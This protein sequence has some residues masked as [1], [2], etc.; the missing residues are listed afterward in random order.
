M[1][2]QITQAEAALVYAKIMTHHG[3]MPFE[4]NDARQFWHEL[5]DAVNLVDA[6]AAVEEFYGSHP[7]T[8]WMRSGDVNILTK[9]MRAKRVPENAEIER[10]MD[11]AGIDSDHATVYRRKLVH[12]TGQGIPLEQ[13]HAIAVEASQR[14]IIEAP[15]PKQK[16]RPVRHFIGHGQAKAGDMSIQDVIGGRGDQ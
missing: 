13:A 10:L 4:K 12:D 8:D 9:R 6:N 16:T 1:S 5:D 3:N 14:L 7:G 11:R 2:K 15:K